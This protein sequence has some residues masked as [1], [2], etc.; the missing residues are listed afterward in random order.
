MTAE[1]VVSVVGKLNRPN[2]PDIPGRETF[3]GTV[4][5]SAGWDTDYVP[6]RRRTSRGDRHRRESRQLHAQDRTVRAWLTLF[7]RTPPWM[8]PT[9]D[10]HDPVSD[11]QKWLYADSLPSYSEW[12]RFWMFWRMGDGAVPGVRVDP[13]W[14]DERQ[15]QRGQRTHAGDALRA[16]SSGSSPTGPTP[17]RRDPAVP[18]RRQAPAARQR[19]LGRHA[20]CDNVTLVTQPIREITP[21][22]IVTTDGDDYADVIVYGTGFQASNFLTPMRFTGCAASNWTTSGTATPARTSGSRSPASRIFLPLRTE[23]RTS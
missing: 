16:T 8:G 17:A 10:Y 6:H 11:G 20:T 2:Y 19:R 7:Q 13:E 5:H 22:G 1:A 4:F 14:D 9:A 23:H 18:A 12:N 21:T 3:A 15:R